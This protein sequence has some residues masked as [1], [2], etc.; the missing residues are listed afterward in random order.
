MFII[1]F[2]TKFN[3][4]VMWR[5]NY[6]AKKLTVMRS[7]H[8]VYRSLP[9]LLLG[10]LSY[11]Y[12]VSLRKCESEISI[13]PQ[14]LPCKSFPV[15]YSFATVQNVVVGDNENKENDVLN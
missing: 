5:T 12:R 1:S 4:T 9:G 3:R 15:Y 13:S 10:S 8:F 14:L 6:K 7:S 2:L 11:F